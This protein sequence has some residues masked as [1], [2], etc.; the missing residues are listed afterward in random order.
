MRES[1]QEAI[2][3]MFKSME[4]KNTPYKP[5]LLY[6]RQEWKDYGPAM[7]IIFTDQELDDAR[8]A[9]GYLGER[10]GVD[11]YVDVLLKTVI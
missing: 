11:C 2:N 8:N 3:K 4:S 9:T 10:K 6:N 1:L 7:G 5:Y